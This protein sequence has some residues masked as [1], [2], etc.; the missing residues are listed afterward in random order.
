MNSPEPEFSD[1]AS[2]FALDRASWH[3][4]KL[5][6]EGANLKAFVDGT[7]PLEYTARQRPVAGRRGPPHEDCIEEQPGAASAGGCKIGLWTEDDS[8]SY[9]KDTSS[10]RNR[11]RGNQ[12]R[13]QHRTATVRSGLYI[14]HG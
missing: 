14:G 8:T 10:I 9:F 6:V 5:S 13:S 12:A 11:P 7:E 2:R 4:L 1:R 3:E